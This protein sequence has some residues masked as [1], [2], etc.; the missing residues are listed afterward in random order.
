MNEK[1]YKSLVV[2]WGAIL[3]MLQ[4]LALI[5]VVG[6]RPDFYN[7]LTRLETSFVAIGMT[8]LIIIYIYLALKNK[9]SGQAIGM[10]IGVLYI[11]TFNIV[12][13]ITG[14][15]F[16]IYCSNMMAELGKID[17][18]KTSKKVTEKNNKD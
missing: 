16:I 8:L 4:A 5:D 7:Q 13:M 15:C 12:N 18:P 3:L 17:T 1:R 11:F 2:I 10:A 9:K 14:I 6:L